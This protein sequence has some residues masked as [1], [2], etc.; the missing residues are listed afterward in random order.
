M[1]QPPR[2]VQGDLHQ[3]RIPDPDAR[4]GQAVHVG[5]DPQGRV[6][7][8]PDPAEPDALLRR[9]V[10]RGSA[11]GPGRTVGRL[12]RGRLHLRQPGRPRAVDV[13]GGVRQHAADPG[14]QGRRRDRRGDR[15]LRHHRLAGQEHPQQQRPGRPVGDLLPRL[16][17]RLRPGGCP[18]RA[19]G[20]VAAGAGDRLVRRRRLPPQRRPLAP[21]RLQLPGRLRSPA[22]RADQGPA[23]AV[24]PRDARRLRVL[25]QDWARCRT[26]TPSTSRGTSPSGPR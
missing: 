22:P 6:Q 21:A 5:P 16:L 26:P 15:H 2:G 14:G 10:R 20:G 4:R 9:P 3:V 23:Q 18:P 1:A 25:P 7:T 13:R 8:A 12:R 11:A 19:Q 17:H 24:R